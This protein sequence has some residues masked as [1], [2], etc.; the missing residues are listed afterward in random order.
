MNRIDVC[1]GIFPSV[2]TSFPSSNC[3]RCPG[4]FALFSFIPSYWLITWDITWSSLFDLLPLF[5]FPAKKHDEHEE[6][7]AGKQRMERSTRNQKRE[8]DREDKCTPRTTREER[9][10]RGNWFASV[11]SLLVGSLLEFVL[12]I[13]NWPFPSLSHAILLQSLLQAVSP[14]RLP[15]EIIFS[16]CRTPERCEKPVHS[17]YLLTWYCRTS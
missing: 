1:R 11:G 16:P 7:S 3:I 15:A 12:C 10:T 5:W 9:S 2:C 6:N 4:C 13:P 8:K 17:W 14:T